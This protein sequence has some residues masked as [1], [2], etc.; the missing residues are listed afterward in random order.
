MKS[1][2]NDRRGAALPFALLLVAL[3]VILIVALATYATNELQA[4][5]NAVHG[6]SARAIAQAGLE[7]AAG[8]IAAGSTNNAFVS[9]QTVTNVGGAWRLETRI[10]NVVATDS[11]RP[12]QRAAVAPVILHSGFA[13]GTNGVDLNFGVRGDPQAG[14]IAPRVN[15]NGWTNLSGDMFRMEWI[16]IYRGPT[17]DPRNLVGRF[18]FWADDESTKLNLNYSGSTNV[19]NAAFNNSQALNISLRGPRPGLA[20]GASTLGDFNGRTWPLDIE[21]GGIA[22]LSRTNVVDLLRWRGVPGDADFRPY[23]SVLGARLGTVGAPGGLA[24]TNLSQ[25]SALSFTATTYS[26]EEERTFQ[27]GRRRYDLMNL[28]SGSPLGTIASFRSALATEFPWFESKYDLDAFAS[29]AYSAVQLPGASTNISQPDHPAAT[30]GS[31]RLYTRG[32][33][34]VNEINLRVLAGEGGGTNIVTVSAYV[35]LVQLGDARNLSGS[36]TEERANSWVPKIAAAT[37]FSARLDLGSAVLGT[38]IPSVE[39][40]GEGGTNWFTYAGNRYAPTQTNFTG[41]LALMTTNFVAHRS[42]AAL[43]FQWPARARLQLSYRGRAYQEIE[44]ELPEASGTFMPAAGQTNV[45]LDLVAE[46]R[47]EGGYRGDPRP[48]Q[49]VTRADSGL[50]GELEASHLNPRATR[51]ARNLD[52]GLELYGN[53]PGAPDLTPPELFIAQDY[54]IPTFLNNMANGFGPRIKGTGWLGEL[55]VATPQGSRYLAWSTPRFW[56]DGRQTMN[57]VEYPPDWLMMDAFHLALYPAS[58][59]GVFSSHGR[60]NINGA[61][62]FFQIST[63]STSRAETVVDSVLLMS[64]TKDFDSAIG[65]SRVQATSTSRTNLL[66]RVQGMTLARNAAGNPYVTPFEFLADLAATN[67]PSSPGWWFSPAAPVLSATNTTDRRIE[68]IV[69]SLN[70]KITTR[71]HQFTV[72]SLGQALQVT[73]AGQTNVVGE[74]YLQAVFERAPGYDESTGAITNSP[75]GAPAIRQLYL[76]ELRY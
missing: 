28:Y 18:A 9:Y 69:R 71:G 59:S 60:L 4:S 66:A 31:S 48:S 53:D 7:M 20:A 63:G 55:P 6:E 14:F 3:N 58:A 21:L 72:F 61:K 13:S 34:V 5:R 8:M 2:P 25:Q 16:L 22:G 43:G 49:F 23:P 76:R 24:V 38:N 45:I 47:L 42:P 10:A 15:G 40:R 29:A 75:G 65:Q 32:L 41:A 37:N 74:S 39:L 70:Q 73:P 50:G 57:G 35:E 33:P 64:E 46:P 54:G 56:G 19:Y 68:G 51:L 26:R 44:I 62:P 1:R 12:W 67:L 17:N 52:P 30:F 36:P 11:Q 27:T